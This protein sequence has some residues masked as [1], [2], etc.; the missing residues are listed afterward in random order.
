MDYRKYPNKKEDD[1]RKNRKIDR[2]KIWEHN[3]SRHN[4][5]AKK[6]DG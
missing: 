3:R 1:N 4:T 5:A 6:G 2:R